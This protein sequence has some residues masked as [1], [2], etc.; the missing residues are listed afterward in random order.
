[1]LY[2]AKLGKWNNR[3]NQELFNFTEDQF[4]NEIPT[5]EL[6]K[7]VH[8]EDRIV[9][10]NNGLYEIKECDSV[11][12]REDPINFGSGVWYSVYYTPNGLVFKIED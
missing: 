7:P 5:L 9:Q 4:F 8:A 1:M 10:T 2:S 3:Q 6:V 11:L 12:Y